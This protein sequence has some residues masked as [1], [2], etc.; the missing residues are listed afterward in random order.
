MIETPWTE[1]WD[2]ARTYL[3]ASTPLRR[4]G[5]PGE[6]AEV[7]EFLLDA[8]YVTGETISVDGGMKLIL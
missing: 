8:T 1:S 6:I 5:E 4:T 2:D 7:V 3:T